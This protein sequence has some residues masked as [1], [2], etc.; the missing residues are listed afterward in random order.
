MLDKV[1]IF[2]FFSHKKYSHSFI[3][4]RLFHGC[5]MD[6]FVDVLGTFLGLE[7]GSS[8]AAYAGSESSRISYKNILIN[9]RVINDRIFIFG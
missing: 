9:K 6:Y 4:L 2:V 5:H 7:R 1:V 8:H 3:K